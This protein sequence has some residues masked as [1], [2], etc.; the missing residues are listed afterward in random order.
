MPRKRVRSLRCPTCRKIVLRSEP[1]FP[2]C[3]ER[4][5]LVDLGKWASGGYVISTPVTDPE[6]FE[7]GQATE[8]TRRRLDPPSEH[9]REHGKH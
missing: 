9:E 2:F 3:S 1:G 6:A 5:R 8:Q 4:C 7:S